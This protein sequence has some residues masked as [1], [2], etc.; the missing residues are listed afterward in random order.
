MQAT[1]RWTTWWWLLPAALAGVIVVLTMVVL[2]PDRHVD[3]W[4]DVPVKTL[5]LFLAVLAV[6]GFP[7]RPRLGAAAVLVTVVAFMGVV[8]TGYILEIS[9]YAAADDQAAA[10]P[11][12]YRMQLFVAAF[13]VVAVLFAYRLGG[14]STER[15]IRTGMASILVVISG[16][17]DLTAWAFGSFEGGRPDTLDWASHIEVFVGAPPTPLVAL[18]FC[19][20]H[21]ALAAV[22]LFAPLPA[23]WRRDSSVTQ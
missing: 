17:N 6:A 4:Y 20:T 13:V 10:F 18:L 15:V 1:R 3:S 9:S 21:F 5:P 19:L 8:D 7:Q 2:P 14:A 12:L 22:F 16:L 11:D 23:R